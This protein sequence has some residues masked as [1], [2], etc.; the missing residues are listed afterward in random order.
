MTLGGLHPIIWVYIPED[1]GRREN[2]M[3]CEEKKGRGSAPKGLTRED[4]ERDGFHKVEFTNGEWT[5]YRKSGNG[6]KTV[7][8][9]DHIGTGKHMRMDYRVGEE[10]RRIPLTRFLYAWFVGPIPEG[11][12]I[13]HADG[14]ALNNEVSNLLIMESGEWREA[15]RG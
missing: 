12:V 11:Y 5:A 7:H 15:F 10:R 9:S 8:P 14:N 4:L 2:H 6:E 1:A 13:V 3:E